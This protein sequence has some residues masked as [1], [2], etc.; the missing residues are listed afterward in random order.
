MFV[1]VGKKNGES[2]GE[3]NLRI[4]PITQNLAL[5]GKAKSLKNRLI[6]YNSRAAEWS[7]QPSWR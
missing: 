7:P 2:A 4:S 5:G 3:F 1:E 6:Q